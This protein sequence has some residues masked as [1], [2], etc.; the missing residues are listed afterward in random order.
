MNT[1]ATADPPALAAD[2]V[3]KELAS[4]SQMPTGCL[5]QAGETVILDMY[6]GKQTFVKLKQNG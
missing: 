4:A 5:A 6:D 3:N 2:T 1:P